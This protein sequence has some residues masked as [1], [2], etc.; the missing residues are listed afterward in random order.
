MPASNLAT[1]LPIDLLE[2]SFFVLANPT[3]QALAASATNSFY[4]PLEL[5]GVGWRIGVRE[6]AGHC[7][8]AMPHEW[9]S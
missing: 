9:R 8:G 4:A 7:W 5:A 3:V 2:L 6:E 1:E